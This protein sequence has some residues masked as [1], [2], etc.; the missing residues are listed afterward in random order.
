MSD[1]ELLTATEI[2]KMIKLSPRHV[3]ERVT[4]RPDFP[5]PRRFGHI[6]RWRKE[7]VRTW[8]EGRKE[9]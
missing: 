7:D 6:R 9:S 5:S 1:E 3:A 4:H 2:A 8:I